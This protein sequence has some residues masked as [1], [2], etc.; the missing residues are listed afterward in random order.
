MGGITKTL[1]KCKTMELC[2]VTLGDMYDNPLIC[3]NPP[4]FHMN[5][6]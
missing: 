6:P 1:D 4:P 5:F 2:L 3:M